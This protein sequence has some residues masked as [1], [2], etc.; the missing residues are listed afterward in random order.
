MLCYLNLILFLLIYQKSGLTTILLPLG[1]LGHISLVTKPSPIHEIC[2]T[3]YYWMTLGILIEASTE[4]MSSGDG[5]TFSIVYGCL[6]FLRAALVIFAWIL[7]IVSMDGAY[8]LRKK[9]C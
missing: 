2:G 5:L 7:M 3:L 4:V 6:F 1:V 8:G 9:F